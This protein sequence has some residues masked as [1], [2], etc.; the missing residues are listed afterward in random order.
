MK[1]HKSSKVSSP[2]GDSTGS[3]NVIGIPVGVAVLH[4]LVEGGCL[5]PMLA[6]VQSE[7]IVMVSAS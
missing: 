4:S 7:Y 5:T 3:E 6:M 2:G 1:K